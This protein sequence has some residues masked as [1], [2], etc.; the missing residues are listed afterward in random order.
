MTQMI[1]DNWRTLD[2]FG[3]YTTWRDYL[4]VGWAIFTVVFVVLSI[5]RLH[6]KRKTDKGS[7]MDSTAI[8][9]LWILLI[10]WGFA[11][12]TAKY[13]G[14]QSRLD[15]A[16]EYY[17][18]EEYDKAYNSYYDLYEEFGEYRDIS[19]RMEDCWFKMESEGYFD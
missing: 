5:L 6:K 17:E 15:V 2:L 18:N 8:L 16:M 7:G 13:K 11:M 12:A 14:I 3:G 4:V 9:I 1:L 19:E 10:L